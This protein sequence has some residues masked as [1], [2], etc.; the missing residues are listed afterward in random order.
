MINIKR[1][2]SI[3]KN[4]VFAGVFILLSTFCPLP[5]LAEVAVTP[6]IN[7][8][9]MGGKYYL[10]GDASSFDGNA[11]LFMS[12]NIKLSEKSEFVPVYAGY[13]S[14]TQDIQELAGGGVLT[15]ERQGHSV[16]LKFI[17]S[18]NFNKIKPRISYSKELVK[19][20][21]DEDWNNGL[22]DYNTMSVG[23]EFEQ[24]RPYG[25]F[26]ESYDFFSV[27]Y[28]NYS[29]LISQSATVID[30]TTFAQL[31]SNSGENTMDNTNHAATF[32]YTWFP[33]PFI[34]KAAYSLTYMQY[35]DQ[36][37]VGDAT[38]SSY[39]KSEKRKDIMNTL[40]YSLWREAKPLNFVLNSHF[41]YLSSNQNSYDTARFKYIDDFYTY[42]QLGVGP[43]INLSLKNGGSFLLGINWNKTYYNGRYTQDA[44]GNYRDSKIY[45]TAWISRF[46]LKYPIMKG[47]SAKTSY[48]YQVSSSNMRYEAD[49]RYNYRASNLLMG[50]E[51]EF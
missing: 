48:S 2:K 10:D 4:I 43:S 37:I 13:Y 26:S 11:N 46:S 49:Y 36:P 8:S 6:V 19:E 42:F 27:K 39:F 22:F 9:L 44:S 33:E 40:R 32:A 28:P 18:N 38:G 5:S 20:T 45:Q 16:S 25:T 12:P 14:G 51:W 34:M 41:A 1:L 47:I 21:N 23:I 29:S 30:T 17:H 3:L 7:L 31:S 50:L 35:P 24:E 15:R